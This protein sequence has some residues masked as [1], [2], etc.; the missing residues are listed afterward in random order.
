MPENLQACERRIRQNE[1]VFRN[2][3]RDMKANRNKRAGGLYVPRD[4]E[5]EA[6]LDEIVGKYLGTPMRSRFTITNFRMPAPD[7]AILTFD[8]IA[9]LSGGGAELRYKVREDG[10]VEYTGS[11]GV[12]MS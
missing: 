12:I 3:L 1:A 4:L 8:D 6:G 10:S 7:S 11:G 9:P 5:T 2:I